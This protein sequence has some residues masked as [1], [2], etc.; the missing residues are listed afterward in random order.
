[1]RMGCLLFRMATTTL[2]FGPCFRVGL[3]IAGWGLTLTLNLT[4]ESPTGA[5]QSPRQSRRKDRTM[6]P[7]N[8]RQGCQWMTRLKR[9]DTG[10][11]GWCCNTPEPTRTTTIRPK[12][13]QP[14][15]LSVTTSA[16][17]QKA[18]GWFRWSRQRR[19]CKRNRRRATTGLTTK[20]REQTEATKIGYKA[21]LAAS[22]ESA[23]LKEQSKC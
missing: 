22:Q 7:I 9:G 17:R 1:M 2:K 23:A 21:M 20:T 3:L 13:K 15:S 5:S 8:Y 11:C 4:L 18:S 10:C 16:Q 14:T 6:T 19:C 12:Q